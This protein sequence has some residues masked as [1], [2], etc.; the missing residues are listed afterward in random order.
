MWSKPSGPEGPSG[1]LVIYKLPEV[2]WGWLFSFLEACRMGRCLL[3]IF[4][5]LVSP[6]YQGDMVWLL[7]PWAG[8]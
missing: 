3:T 5:K 4:V 7:L 6:G 8:L 2:G 1:S